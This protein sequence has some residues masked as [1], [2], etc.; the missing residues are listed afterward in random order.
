LIGSATRDRQR[1]AQAAR[2]ELE[3]TRSFARRDAEIFSRDQIIEGEIDEHLQTAKVDHADQAST[4]DHRVTRSKL[5]LIDVEAKKADDA[6]ARSRK[7]LEGLEIRAPHDGV[8]TLKRSWTGETMR[9]GDTVFRSMSVADI[10][11]VAKMEAEL[12]VLEA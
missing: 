2:R 9:V 4:V 12:F 6:I 5:G 1:V 8:F 10:S 7:G 11:L 3:L